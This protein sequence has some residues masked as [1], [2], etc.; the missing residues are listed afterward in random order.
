MFRG[1][2][3]HSEASERPGTPRNILGGVGLPDLSIP[4]TNGGGAAFAAVSAW[5]A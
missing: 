1:V 4:S 5:N 2:P 3:R